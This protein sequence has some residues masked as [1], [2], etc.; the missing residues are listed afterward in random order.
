MAPGLHLTQPRILSEESSE[1][2]SYQCSVTV[3][4]EVAMDAILA[5]KA[6]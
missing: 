5:L 2:G 6:L 4:L 3:E 1:S